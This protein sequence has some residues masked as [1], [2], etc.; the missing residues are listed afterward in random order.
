MQPITQALLDLQEIDRKLYR[1]ESE[2][3]RLPAEVAQREHELAQ[4][5]ARIA[6]LTQ[7][8][9]ATR[10]DAKEV[11]DYTV[12]MRQRQR[13]LESESTKGKI[14]AAMLASYQHEIR[15]LKRGIS[16]A[17]DEALRK[18]GAAEAIEKERAE[19]EQRLAE[20]RRIFEEFQSNVEKELAVAKAR[21][22]ELLAERQSASAEGVP[23]EALELYRRLLKTREGEA[24]SELAD[25]HCQSCFVQ[26][27]RNL[28][29]RLAKGE[30]V[31]CPSCTRIL[32]R[33]F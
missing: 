32:Y 5:E 16:E 26:I 9:A 33:T 28:G 31:Q 27:P 25:G 30:I 1:V 7:Q 11:E 29:V 8:A 2:L 10:R 12:G 13:K 20:E 18:L 6:E 19:L 17:E 23:P 14:D 3:E 4:I 15:S 21:Q 22:A 24:L